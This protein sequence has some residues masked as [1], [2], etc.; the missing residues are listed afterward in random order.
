M[1]DNLRDLERDIVI[2][3]LPGLSRKGLRLSPQS[4][5]SILDLLQQKAS[6]IVNTVEQLQK[7]GHHD[8]EMTSQ[9]QAKFAAKSI[10]KNVSKPGLGK[11]IYKEGK[12]VLRFF[13]ETDVAFIFSQLEGAI[14][15]S[16]IKIFAFKSGECL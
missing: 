14:N 13:K 10:E 11:V 9:W 5:L 15:T 7:M 3:E 12:D 16:Q 4:Y 6:P 2:K 8:M 1:H